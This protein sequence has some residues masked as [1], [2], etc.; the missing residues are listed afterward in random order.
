M[1]DLTMS[2]NPSTYCDARRTSALQIRSLVDWLH[3]NDHY[4]SL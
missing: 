1:I 2:N 4:A 3:N